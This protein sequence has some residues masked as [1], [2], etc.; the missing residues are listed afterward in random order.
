VTEVFQQLF[1][2]GAVTT[3]FYADDHA[4]TELLVKSAYFVFVL[5]FEVVGRY[6]SLVSFQRTDSL[7]SCM[8]VNADIYCAHSA[9]FQSPVTEL[10]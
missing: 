7:L 6:H 1:E 5:M 9:S 10:P 2:P 8:K 4:L 3:G